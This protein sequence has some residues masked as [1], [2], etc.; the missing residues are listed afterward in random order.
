MSS[1]RESLAASKIPRK[2]ITSKLGQR[3]SISKNELTRRSSAAKNILQSNEPVKSNIPTVRSSKKVHKEKVVKEA[4]EIPVEK[5]DEVIVKEKPTFTMIPPTAN[6][7]ESTEIL[8]NAINLIYE[9]NMPENKVQFFTNY[10][11][12][13]LKFSQSS[14]LLSISST[15]MTA[16]F[17]EK[18]EAVPS[19]VLAE[20][21]SLCF[22]INCGDIFLE[23]EDSFEA[24]ESIKG[25]INQSIENTPVKTLVKSICS[26]IQQSSG[27]KLQ[28]ILDSLKES[29]NLKSAAE[30][31]LRAIS[32]V[33][34][35]FH[36][37][38]TLPEFLPEPSIPDVSDITKI[39]GQS[40][41]NVSVEESIARLLN[42][43]VVGDE[44]LRLVANSKDGK[45]EEFPASI[46]VVLH[47]AWNEASPCPNEE[48]LLEQAQFFLDTHQSSE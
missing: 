24:Q 44:L 8:M 18:F 36:P 21:L 20:V 10:A 35:S 14:Q 39:K 1:R 13:M 31:E 19:E 46:R 2:S 32:D 6:E 12:A 27:N 9:E 3:V 29:D 47:A 23:G 7:A 42:E 41:E 43:E 30:I 26:I 37:E 11:Q 17:Q 33:L 5:V 28:F 22:S 34:S 4:V 25:F 40:N 38:I 48:E 15:C 16:L 45:F